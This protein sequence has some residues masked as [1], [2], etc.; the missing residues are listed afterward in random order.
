MLNV[1]HYT[2]MPN[3]LVR[4]NVRTDDIFVN[5]RIYNLVHVLAITP[6]FT[7][8]MKFNERVT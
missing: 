1:I 7:V 5:S 4:Y 2:S 8:H 6:I 3:V